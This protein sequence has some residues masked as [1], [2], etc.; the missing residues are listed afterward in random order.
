MTTPGS[1]TKS[2]VCSTCGHGASERTLRAIKPKA[3]RA[4]K[5][6]KRVSRRTKVK[7]LAAQYMQRYR[8]DDG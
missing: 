3:K 8:K 2:E 4:G 7:K 1:T 6:P 5:P